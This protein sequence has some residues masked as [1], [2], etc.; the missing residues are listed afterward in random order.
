MSGGRLR[1]WVRAGALCAF[2]VLFDQT[3]KGLV[4]EK[5]V[6]GELV[7]VLGPLRLTLSHNDGVAFGLAGGG[8]AGLI[9]IT[10]AALA[11]VA[12]LFARNPTRPGMWVAFGL[13]AGG[14]IGNLA[15]RIRLGA[16]TDFIDLPHWPNF[17]LADISVTAGVVVL[18][19]IYLRDA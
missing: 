16:V 11:L 10:L 4:E 9:V 2:V 12:V 13:I 18:A 15:D 1:A 19:Y 8:G 5:I 3:A 14:A 6:V 17:N 7:D